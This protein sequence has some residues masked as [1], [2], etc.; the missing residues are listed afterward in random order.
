M[1]RLLFAAA[2][3]FLLFWSLPIAAQAKTQLLP[4][5]IQEVDSETLK[6]LLLTFE[7]AEEA[8]RTRDLDGI[9]TLY[10]DNY[11]YHGLTKADIQKI[12]KQLFEHYK[13]LE[14]FHTFSV[15]RMTEAEGKL[16]AEIT[17][18]GVIWGTAND[19]AL[20]LPVDSWYEEIHYLKKDNGRCRIVGNVGGDS[21]PVVQFGVA[22]HPLF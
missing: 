6:E 9:T 10:S 4:G 15:V 16:I 11:A 17:C 12:W 13:E 3:L 20:R 7:Q 21:L 2:S 8:I 14:S 22:A 5:A 18:S 1:N 19:T